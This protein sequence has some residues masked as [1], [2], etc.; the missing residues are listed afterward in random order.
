MSNFQDFDL[1]DVLQKALIRIKYVTP[2]PIQAQAVPMALAGKDILGSAQTGTGKTAAFLLPLITYLLS[3]KEETAI[4]LAPTRELAMQIATFA[5]QLMGRMPYTLLIGGDSMSKQLN[6]LRARPR[7]IVGTPGRV[8]D[9]LERGSL[10]LDH[11]HFLVL[12]EA[13]RMLDMGFGIQ[14]DSIVKRMPKQKQT[15]MFSATLPTG[16]TRL[17]EKYMSNPERISVETTHKIDIDQQIIHVT[18][19]TKY[20]ELVQALESRAGSIIL[21]VK[22]KM[23]TEKLAY[24]LQKEEHNAD[25]I[26]GDLK[27]SRRERVIRRFKEGKF[28]ILVATDV[29]ARGID[30]PHIGHVINYD[31]P[32]CPEDYVHRIGRTARA[33]EKGA[34]LSLIAPDDRRKWTE[35]DHFL[36]PSKKRAYASSGGGPRKGSSS[37]PRKYSSHKGFR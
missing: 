1:P 28:R 31:L 34:S 8:N 20:S 22:T 12:D 17:A 6:Q 26:H 30:I 16:I 2:T 35:I 37:A 27:Q 7:L 15:L 3:G 5:A 24:K 19:D 36:N 29:A 25:F 23:G 32:Q 4:V 18:N 33:G 11:T 9:H 13:D 10:K 14:I 21:F